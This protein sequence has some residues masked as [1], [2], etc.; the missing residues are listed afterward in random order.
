MIENQGIELK[1]KKFKGVG[2]F[3]KDKLMPLILKE[4]IKFSRQHPKK[5]TCVDIQQSLSIKSI[6]LEA[7]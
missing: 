2:F 4:F 1:T 5:A 6:I 7:F 3:F